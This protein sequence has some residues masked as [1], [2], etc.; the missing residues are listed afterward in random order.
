ME[1]KHKNKELLFI[2]YKESHKRDLHKNTLSGW[3]RKLIPPVYKTAEGGGAS[4]H[5]VLKCSVLKSIFTGETDATEYWLLSSPLN[6]L[7][8]L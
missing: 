4:M 7:F 8:S 2:S 3:V 1:D 6:L 5:E